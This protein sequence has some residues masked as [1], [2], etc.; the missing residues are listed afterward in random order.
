M[1]RYARWWMTLLII[2]GSVGLLISVSSCRREQQAEFQP[3][4][5][6]LPQGLAGYEAMEIPGD[7]PQTPEKVALGRQLFFDKRLSADESLSCYS[8]HL[9]EKGLSD[10]RP[11]AVGALGKKL[12]RNSPTL[13]NIGY[14]KEF[15]WDGRA[16]PLEKQVRAAWTGANMSANPDEIAAKLNRIEGYRKQFQ[17]VFGTDATPDAIVKALAAYTRTIIGGTTA[18]DRYRLGDSSALSEEAKRGLEVFKRVGCDQ[19]HAGI[20]FTDL[21]YHNV[22]I[23][24]DKPEPDLGRFKVTNQQ[25]DKGAFKTPTLRDVARSGPY[26]HDGSVA[27][28]EE[29]V[30]LMLAG[31][32]PNPWLDR[33]NLKP[34]KITAEERQ[35][36]LVFLRSLT[37][38][39]QLK[40]PPLPQQ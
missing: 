23:G 32:K 9:N 34:A 35:A 15:Y 8:C 30:D 14:H 4:I 2:G 24:M 12:P 11:T 31:G 13:W 20:L 7:N 26:F 29:A 40:E 5:L 1:P 36:L 19:C 28:L 37:E 6:P 18:Y 27:T 22:G 38:E 21:Q 16:S 10:G 3:E 25:K 17:R 33:V 39:V